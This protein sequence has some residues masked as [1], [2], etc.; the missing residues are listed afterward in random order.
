MI[1]SEVEEVVLIK[2]QIREILVFT[3]ITMVIGLPL[4]KYFQSNGQVE[5]SSEEPSIKVPFDIENNQPVSSV[6]IENVHSI[7]SD[8]SK[9]NTLS[10][11]I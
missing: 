4:K 8:I 1:D 5:L 6:Q 11:E 10:Q 9:I 7:V 3:L 2:S